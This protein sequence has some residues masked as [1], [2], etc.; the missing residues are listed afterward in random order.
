MP[1]GLAIKFSNDVFAIR[2]ISL[3]EKSMVR[4]FI[5]IRKTRAQQDYWKVKKESKKISKVHNRTVLAD[6]FWQDTLRAD[7]LGTGRR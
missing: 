5:N 3:S 4:W 6:C 1:R 7:L 2:G